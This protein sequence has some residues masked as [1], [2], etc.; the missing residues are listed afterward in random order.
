MNIDTINGRIIDLWQKY[1]K[2]VTGD[3]SPLLYKD[4]KRD[5]L[6]FIGLNPSYSPRGFKKFLK[7]SRYEGISADIAEINKYHAF[8]NIDKYRHDIMEMQAIAFEKYDYFNPIRDIAKYVGIDWNHLD[9]FYQRIT[10]QKTLRESLFKNGRIH[11]FAVEQLKIT[12][13]IIDYLNP[14]VIVIINA[15]ARDIM[16]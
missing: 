12:T 11:D 6:L 15:L 13:D 1:D 14:K 4:F 9:L 2:D 5:A 3:L 10:K 7:G 16:K 8:K